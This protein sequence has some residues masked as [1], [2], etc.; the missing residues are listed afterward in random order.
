MYE[1]DMNQIKKQFTV[2]IKEISNVLPQ[3]YNMDSIIN[4]IKE[5]Y[6]FEFR[7]LEEKYEK[8]S[9]HDKKLVKVKGKKRFFMKKPRKILEDL[10]ITKKLLSEEYKQSY[11]EVFQQEQIDSNR[12]LLLQKRLPKI[13][14]K[15][16]KINKAIS[17]AQQ[18][19][20]EFLDRLM[21]L[22]DQTRST[23]KDK[24]YIMLELE[25]YYCPK[26]IKFFKKTVHSE[27]NY[28]L[29]EMAVKH[30]QSL[31][32]YAVL[33]KQKYMRIHTKN[34]KNKQDKKKYAK[35]RF[36]IQAI[37]EELEYR[38]NNSKEQRIK[39]FDYFISHS[40]RDFLEVQKLI[41]NLNSNRK[42]IYCDWIN[43]TDYLKRHL[44]CDATLM[45]IRKRIE[46]SRAIVLVESDNSI[47]S[48]WVKYELNYGMS[49]NKPIY[50]IKKNHMEDFKI[51]KLR[52]TWFIDK[53]FE[54][55][56]LY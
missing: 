30:L 38:I 49:L 23:Q 3:K 2:Y 19:E 28:Q 8:Y 7:I 1:Q 34:K 32:H 35:E 42:N 53:E 39:T 12:E 22:Y 51:Q 31:G 6:P 17:K 11:N 36:N 40:S 47:N 55:L 56:S 46:Q 14:K 13:K 25:K 52:D 5:F 9:I 48:K 10:P 41:N 4:L 33:R 20:P 15:Q 50:Y 16:D 29:R 24:V 45:V 37:P 26:V 18:M 44:V 21:G 27:Q 43:D 54:K